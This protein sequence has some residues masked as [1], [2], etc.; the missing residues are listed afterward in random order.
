M[1]FGC[2]VRDEEGRFVAAKNSIQ[3]GTFNP[4]V[5][6]AVSMREALSW[7][8]SRS[9]DLLQVESDAQKVI[10]EPHA[11]PFTSFSDVSLI[12][13]DIREIIKGFSHVDF[14]FVRRTANQVAHGLAKQAVVRAEGLEWYAT[15][16]D[17]ILDSL[18][19]D[20]SF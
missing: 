5:A 1:G 2:I 18:Y 12:V 8:K 15:P 10:R 11:P 9:Y 14:S 4:A 17:F 3:H 20:S 13:E 6:E 16:P 7:L 19:V